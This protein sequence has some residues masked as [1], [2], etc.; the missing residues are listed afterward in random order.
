MK[1]LW[2]KVLSSAMAAM[3]SL[4]GLSM[5][6]AMSTVS[7]AEEATYGEEFTAY[8]GF[9]GD[10]AEENDWGLQYN[11]PENAGNAGDIVATNATLKVGDTVTIALEFPSAVV[12]TW[13]MAPVLALPEDAGVTAVDAE[14]SLKIDGEDVAID[15]AAGDAW[16]VEATGDYAG[17]VRLAGGFNE[18]GAQ[19]IAEPAGFTK[20]EY[21]ITV[22][23]IKTGASEALEASDY[24]GTSTLYIGFGGDAAE[25]NDWGLQY[26]DPA[27][28]GNAGDITAV[29]AEG[30]KVGDTVSVS[31]EFAAPVVNVWWMAPVLVLDDAEATAV[32]VDATV[33][34]KIDDADV[35]I[36]AAAGDAWWA[37]GTG[38]YANALRL[39]GGFNEWGAQ[40]IAEPSGFSKVEYTVTI[41]SI[42]VGTPAAAEEEAVQTEPVDLGGTYN[43]YIGLQ[44]PK[45]TF[46]DAYDNE[47]TGFGTDFFN[48][49]TF[50][51]D[52]A[53][54]TS[55]PA[56][57][58]D[59]QIAGN[60]TYTVGATD[61]AWPD[62]EFSDQDYMNLIFFSTDIP[63]SGEIT[64][65]DVVLKINGSEVS[66]INPQFEEGSAHM[67]CNIQN[68]WVDELKTIGYYGVPFSSIEIS[69]TVSG[70]NYDAAVAEEPAAEPAE[71]T[72][73]AAESTTEEA[74]AASSGCSS[75]SAELIGTPANNT[76]FAGVFGFAAIAAVGVAVVT[77]I[78]KFR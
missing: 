28:A 58:N 9:G 57:F 16:W 29:N 70:F 77:L 56:T 68:I 63:N 36:D 60:G 7:N 22:K 51:G 15:A 42:Q 6:P 33:A 45:Y 52:T 50:Q 69:F 23:D 14:V 41:N 74:P 71:T 78:K 5:L 44:G 21:T 66:D 10:A 53:E 54:K 40:Y 26:N 8:I 2:K 4:A 25:E 24:A 47:A 59:V 72:E 35:A 13:W 11:D 17:A 49:L 18:W 46:R 19:Y 37:E 75:S 43:A 48:Q 12:N 31:L 62:D 76:D 55:V 34:L 27:N 39:A 20:V 30:L 1:K 73:P 38:D 65:S 32:S 67:Q 3:L 64:I 61:I